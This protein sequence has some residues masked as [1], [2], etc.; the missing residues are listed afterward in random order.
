MWIEFIDNNSSVLAAARLLSRKS[1]DE[2]VSAAEVAHELALDADTALVSFTR[3][4][5]MDWMVVAGE[6]WSAPTTAD[7]RW[8]TREHYRLTVGK[9]YEVLAVE[10]DCF[11]ILDD[12][13]EPVV[14]HRSGFRI[15]D[16]AEPTFWISD[17]DEDGDRFTCPAEWNRL[18]FFEDYHD[19]SPTACDQFWTDL[20]RLYPTTWEERRRQPTNQDT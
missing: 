11:R 13:D 9:R 3:L 6:D 17:T 8:V 2:C 16:D 20:R 10:A 4:M 5:E 14:Y 1:S 15:V 7:T 18:G 12:H 19:G